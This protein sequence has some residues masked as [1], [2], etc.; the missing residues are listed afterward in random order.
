VKFNKPPLYFSPL[1]GPRG[2]SSASDKTINQRILDKGVL[3]V[4][5][6]YV[7]AGERA[8][9]LKTFQG[10]VLGEIFYGQYHKQ[11]GGSYPTAYVQM[12]QLEGSMKSEIW[13]SQHS[14]STTDYQD[15]RC[16]Y[17]EEI[18]FGVLQVPISSLGEEFERFTYSSYFKVFDLLKHSGYPHLIRIWNYFPHIN[19]IEG[20]LEVYRRFSRAR[21]QAFGDYDER[22]TERLSAASAVGAHGGDLCI[23]FIASKTPGKPWEN[24]RQV[25]AYYYPP[26]YGPRSPSFARATWK[27]WGKSEC[28]YI[29]GTASIVG[30]ETCNPGDVLAQLSETLNNIEVLIDHIQEHEHSDL[31]ISDISHIKAYIR[32]EMDYP[33]VKASLDYRFGSRVETLYVNADVCR[34]DLLLEIEAIVCD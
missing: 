28:L 9:F 1:A 21:H 24:P 17:N 26:Q 15:I 32:S 10:R 19:L 16:T 13:I 2:M 29:S 34:S 6:H 4:E 7:C 27:T 5:L 23:Y 18:L 14:V 11:A 8:A 25:S 3:P 20:N 31:S 12:N 22:F 33:V 30:H